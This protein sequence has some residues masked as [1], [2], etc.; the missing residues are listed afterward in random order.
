MRIN[1]GIGNWGRNLFQKDYVPNSVLTCPKMK[2][3]LS[4]FDD[5]RHCEQKKDL[6]PYE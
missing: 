3:D 2:I 1:N 6:K 4:L 5:H